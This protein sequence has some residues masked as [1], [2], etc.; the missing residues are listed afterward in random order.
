MQ[1]SIHKTPVGFPLVT[2]NMPSLSSVCIA[3]WVRAGSRL[4]NVSN[5]GISHFLEHMAFK[6]GRK[7]KTARIVAKTLE[8]MGASYNAATSKEWTSFYVKVRSGLLEKAFD[9]LSDMLMNPVFSPKEIEK[10]RGVILQEIAMT[11]DN[12]QERLGLIFSNLIFGDH[13]L[14]RD[15]AGTIQSVGNIGKSDIQVYKDTYYV[16]DNCIL[17]VAGKFNEAEVINFTQKYFVSKSGINADFSKYTSYQKKP[18]FISEYKDINQ[19]NL[20]MGFPAYGRNSNRKNAQWLLSTVLGTGMSSRLFTQVREN[21]GLA[22]AVGTS[23]S[24]NCDT[25]VFASYAG[26]DPKKARETVKVIID[27]H[28]KISGGSKPITDSELKKSKEFIKGSIALSF[29]DTMSVSNFYAKQVMFDK[30][31]INPADLFK[32]IDNISLQEVNSLSKEIFS[33]NKFNLA[34]VGP[35]TDSDRSFFAKLP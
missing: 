1:Y 12:P 21:R 7:Y 2:V 22:Y 4:E 35:L 16:S 24:L 9:V 10:E 20:L 6:G 25:G 3:F 34:A 23:V 18:R 13:P 27:E 26:V 14:G 29:E 5:Q 15:I 31:I 33:F 11:N 8:G 17:T 32:Q 30:E 28:Q 19:T